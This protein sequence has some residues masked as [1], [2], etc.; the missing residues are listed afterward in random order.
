MLAE[1][2]AHGPEAPRGEPGVVGA[3]MLAEG[4]AG[5]LQ[6]LP[7]RLVGGHRAKHHVGMTDHI[8][9]AGEAGELHARSSG[10]EKKWRR[11][12]IFE[13][14]DGPALHSHRPTSL[15]LRSAS[16]QESACQTCYT[17]GG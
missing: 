4:A 9:G 5:L 14:S 10:R 6:D 11:P 12:C 7:V 8:F 13:P 15:P 2:D 16:C 3:D 1:A 17:S